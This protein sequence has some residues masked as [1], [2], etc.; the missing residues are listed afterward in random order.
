MQLKVPRKRVLKI[1]E[2]LTEVGSPISVEDYV[3]TILNGLPFEY[4]PFVTSILSSAQPYFVDEMKALLMS[5]QDRLERQKQ[6]E[7]CKICMLILSKISILIEAWKVH[8]AKDGGI[9]L[10]HSK[11]I[12]NLLH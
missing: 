4:D 5:Q 12:L 11:Y 3:E 7:S 2:T 1:V 6:H 9:H 10:S 8:T